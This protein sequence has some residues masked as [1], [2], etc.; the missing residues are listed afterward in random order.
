MINNTHS[1]V[2]SLIKKINKVNVAVDCTC[3]NGHD[4]ENILNILNPEKLYC[5]DIQ[6]CAINN[7]KEKLKNFKNS[8]IVYIRDSYANI[9]KYVKEKIDF[10]IF[11]LGY[12]PKYNHNIT[13]NYVEVI[14]ALNYILL[15][16]QINS[17]VILT[18]YPGH[19]SGLNEAKYV[20]KFLSKLNQRMYS[21]I[22]YEFINQINNPP[23]VIKI[24]KLF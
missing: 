5:F 17:N 14:K 7:T 16:M 10:V 6:E 18:F 4:S 20:S 22:K 9:N 23:F 21:V 1:L 2:K 13:T 11:N 19:S 8:E 24:T 15:N 12:L 3:G